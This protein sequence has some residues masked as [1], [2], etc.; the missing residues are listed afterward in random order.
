[1]LSTN[2]YDHDLLQNINAENDIE[3][4]NY[5]SSNQTISINK[6]IINSDVV[7]LG[8]WTP[9]N[10]SLILQHLKEEQKNAI[11]TLLNQ[12]LHEYYFSMNNFEDHE[13]TKLTEELLKSAQQT[14][15]KIIIIL[16]PP[17]EGRPDTSYDWK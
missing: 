3:D 9:I 17:S 16:L 6:N 12:G 13:Y 2:T 11:R 5:N 1:M 4:R 8:A 7:I 14:N 15:L 10:N